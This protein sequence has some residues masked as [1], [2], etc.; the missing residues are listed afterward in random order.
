[1]APER[2]RFKAGTGGIIASPVGAIPEAVMNMIY[3]HGLGAQ[4]CK[5]WTSPNEQSHGGHAVCRFASDVMQ[6]YCINAMVAQ[7]YTSERPWL[8]VDVG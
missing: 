5:T 6:A 1:M 4:G 8:I 2:R 7:M 3:D